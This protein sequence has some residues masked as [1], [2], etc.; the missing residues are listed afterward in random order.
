MRR[1]KGFTLAELLI[2]VAIIAILVGIS[3]P[4]FTSQLEKSRRAVD[5]ANARNIEAVL[6]VAANSNEI[7]FTNKYVEG[8]SSKYACIAV[9]VGK[10]KV[11]YYVSG[12]IKINGI[13][14]NS[15]DHDYSRL[16]KLLDKNNILDYRVKSNDGWNF[17][18]VFL[19]SDGTMKIGSGNDN[20]FNEYE[21]NTFETHANNWK[22][23][24]DKS[25]IEK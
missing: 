1:N 17:Y 3:I 21:D 6:G 15:G 2:I 13:D 10:D 23:R 14:F 9:I 18:A 4:I 24:T 20:G 22:N 8:S 25:S 5:K 12:N 11:K 7:E 16:K 19:Y